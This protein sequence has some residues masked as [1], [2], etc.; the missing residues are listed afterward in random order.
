MNDPSEGTSTTTGPAAVPAEAETIVLE[1]EAAANDDSA[2]VAASLPASAIGDVLAS[3]YQLLDLV[4]EGGMSR[5]YR[6]LDL[7]TDA[8][9]PERYLALK[10]FVRPVVDEVDVY[11]ALQAEIA[12]L[13]SLSHPNIVRIHGCDREGS[14][15]F[16]TMELLAGQ[17]LYQRLQAG[18]VSDGVA[19]IEAIGAALDYAHRHQVVHGD[20]KPGNVVLPKEG[21][22]KVIDFSIAGLVA[23]PKTASERREAA[24]HRGSLAVTPRYASP[25]LMLRHAPVPADDVY[26]LACLSYEVL[27]GT[28]PFDQGSG[29][30]ALSVPP[31]FKTGLNS[32]QYDAIVN[33]LRFERQ[34]RTATIGQFMTEFAAPIQVAGETR[35]SR[36]AALIAVVAAAIIAG[37][38]Y[39]HSSNPPSPTLVEQIPRAAGVMTPG[40]PG[41]VFQDCAECSPMRV[42]PAGRFKQGAADDDLSASPVEKP[43]HVV[44]L[45]APLAVSTNDVTVGEFGRFVAETGREMNGCDVYDGSWH[46]QANASWS[47]PGFEQTAN[48][49]VTCV[50]WNDAVAYA[51]W[52]SA[53]QG[54]AYRLPSASEWEYAARGGLDA[55]R[56]WGR[57]S[58]ACAM[59]NVADRS[60]ARR[61]PGWSVFACEDGH[62][63]TAPVGSFQANAFGLNDMLGNLFQWTQDCWRA[64]YVKAPTDGSARS[65]GDCAQHELRGGSWFSTPR[66]VS[67]SHR[68]RFAADYRTSSVGFRLVR[69]VEP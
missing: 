11:T 59:A 32:S 43:Q 14:T 66:F 52:L 62:V 22:L 42:L 13:S 28:H 61:Y 21:G 49:P 56:P 17:S 48:H 29:A 1:D 38:F 41:M 4:G 57:E 24:Q 20:L 10:I 3:R 26:A 63:N 47:N 51:Q 68:N 37:W 30:Q 60:A 58:D 9:S 6:A 12:R 34:H 39:F 46:V 44:D 15:V 69:M 19:I 50:S 25:Q 18:P 55:V 33:G 23:P 16:I 53:K 45:A 40:R 54:H 27:T 5:V 35:R 64:D 36:G 7:R 31:A 67:A 8:T 65:D 2:P